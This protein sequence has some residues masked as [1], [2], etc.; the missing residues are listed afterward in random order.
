MTRPQ[1]EAARNAAYQAVDNVGL[2][3]KPEAYDDLVGGIADEMAA[4][5]LNPM[6]HPKA[7]SMLDDIR[8][9]RG[10]PTTLTELDQLRQVIRRD[11]ASSS[12][13]AE[14]F[15]GQKMIRNIDEFIQ[16]AG[17]DQVISGDPAQAATAI[18]TARDLHT[19]LKKLDTFEE[20]L[21][22]ADLRA[23]STGSGGNVDNAT[24]QN[25]RR[26]IETTRNL[27]PAERKAAER[28]VRGGPVQNTLRTIGKLSPQGNGLMTALGIGGAM[29]NPV[30]G[31][32][33]LVGVGAKA[34]ADAMTRGNTD[35]LLRLIINGGRPAARVAPS[36]VVRRPVSAAA[37]AAMVTARPVAA[38][39][40]K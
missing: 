8:S 23:A 11:V 24:R 33:S 20:A 38:K 5:R 17:P 2:Q 39:E 6:R 30:L 3:F 4:A 27:T 1:L 29:T 40:R 14:R 32:P 16:A 13:E 35:D 12:D 21:G 15:F 19:R 18:R 26:V 36:A 10:K 7:A 31:I 28:V 34:V 22:K 9:L 37:S 25:V